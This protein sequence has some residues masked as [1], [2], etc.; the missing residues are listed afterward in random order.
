MLRTAPLRLPPLSATYL[1]R[2]PARE[3]AFIALSLSGLALGISGA[4]I[5]G[6]DKLYI[7]A[8]ESISGSIAT[9]TLAMTLQ[10][11]AANAGVALDF[12]LG[13]TQQS[14]AGN[15]LNETF[16]NPAKAAATLAP[17]TLFGLGAVPTTSH[18][19]FQ[20]PFTWHAQAWST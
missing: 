13:I 4:D 9:I 10:E 18:G 6:F 16:S 12:V 5:T 20:L 8:K 17:D 7:V 11:S 2:H 15:G 14:T 1:R 19:E 3:F